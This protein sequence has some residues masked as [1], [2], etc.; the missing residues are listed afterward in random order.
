LND[1]IK[2]LRRHELNRCPGCSPTQPID[3]DRIYPSRHR[4]YG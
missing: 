3:W 4:A 1:A 2:N